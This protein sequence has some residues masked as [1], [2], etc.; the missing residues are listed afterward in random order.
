MA[1][2]K[3]PEETVA[4]ILDVAMRLFV[5]RG[6]EQTSMQ[7]IIDELG[8]LTKGAVYHHFSSKEEILSLIHI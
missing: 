6:Y 8:G 4:K 5:E 7:N 3:H 2:N 1:R